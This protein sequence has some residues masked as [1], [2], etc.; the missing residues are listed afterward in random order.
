MSRRVTLNDEQ[1]D[2]LRR[3]LDFCVGEVDERLGRAQAYSID[4]VALR[5]MRD[6]VD[7]LRLYIFPLP[8]GADGQ[9]TCTAFEEAE[10][11][12]GR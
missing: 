5:L 3:C 12:E 8:T 11:G 4:T 1:L 10:K 6:R 2:V 7:A 9:P